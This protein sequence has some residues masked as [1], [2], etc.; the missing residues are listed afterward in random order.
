MNMISLLII[1][2]SWLHSHFSLSPFQSLIVPIML[3]YQLKR[4]KSDNLYTFCRC[5]LCYRIL[6][7]MS[8]AAMVC[9]VNRYCWNE[10]FQKGQ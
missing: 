6:H 7:W 1:I 5:K 8:F 2:Y 3:S 4:S 9:P 10:P